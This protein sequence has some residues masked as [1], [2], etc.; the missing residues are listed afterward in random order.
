MDKLSRRSFG[1]HLITGA[2]V[3]LSIR[4]AFPQE[5]QPAD[6]EECVPDAI[7]GY[8]PSAEERALAIKFLRNHRQQMR[9]LGNQTPP[10]ET[11]P[12]FVFASPPTRKK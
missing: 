7:A 3:P 5:E 9:E 2:L 1:K 11:P 8:T 4:N 10:H 6:H 12:A